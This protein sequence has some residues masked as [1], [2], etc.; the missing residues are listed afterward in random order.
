MSSYEKARDIA[1]K[2]T[3]ILHIN[4]PIGVP[5]LRLTPQ[6]VLKRCTAEELDFYHFK[7]FGEGGSA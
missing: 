7:I 6:D 1:D 4:T 2:L 5:E 3:D